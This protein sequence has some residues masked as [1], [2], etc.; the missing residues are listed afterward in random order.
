MITIEYDSLADAIP[1]GKADQFVL[2]LKAGTLV[3]CS[4]ENVFLSA[5]L[6]VKQKK[7]SD[8]EIRFKYQDKFIFLN[9][10]GRFMSNPPTGF[11]TFE[12][13]KIRQLM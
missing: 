8:K 3:K 12:L 11:C 7:I 4:T 13:E 9:S 2:A 5:R 6:L 10:D 1:D